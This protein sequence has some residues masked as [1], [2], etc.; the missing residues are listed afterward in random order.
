[1]FRNAYS[2][3]KNGLTINYNWRLV[4]VVGHSP[5]FSCTGRQKLWSFIKTERDR[6]SK[7]IQGLKY[8]RCQTKEMTSSLTFEMYSKRTWGFLHRSLC[9]CYCFFY[10][11]PPSQKN[12]DHYDC[13]C[14]LL[15][16][17]TGKNLKLGIKEEQ[18]RIITFLKW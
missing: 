16:L 17:E 1:M 8:C 11:H 5:G 7:D 2:V 18:W 15:L 13:L 6:E 4:C 12:S 10:K 14:S 3:G 9:C